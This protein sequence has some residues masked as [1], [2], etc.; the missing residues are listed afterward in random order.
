MAVRLPCLA[1]LRDIDQMDCKCD[2]KCDRYEIFKIPVDLSPVLYPAA[3]TEHAVDDYPVSEEHEIDD[4]GRDELSADFF[5]CG[6]KS[7][8]E[9]TETED[10]KSIFPGNGS[11]DDERNKAKCG[12]NGKK[13]LSGIIVSAA[14]FHKLYLEK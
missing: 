5:I 12:S 1:S 2:D 4:K 6:I 14:V 9:N 13:D 7:S 10:K 8:E 3:Q 11:Y